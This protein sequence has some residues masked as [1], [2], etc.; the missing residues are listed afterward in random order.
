MNLCITYSLGFA[1]VHN[2]RQRVTAYCIVPVT[3]AKRM[4]NVSNVYQRIN[5]MSH[6]SA[7]AVV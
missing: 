6:T 5:R 1:G 2:V 7:Y 4:P 3:Y